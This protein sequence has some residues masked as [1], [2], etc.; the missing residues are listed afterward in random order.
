[1]VAGYAFKRDDA[2]LKKILELNTFIFTSKIFLAAMTAP[3]IRF[4]FPNLTGYNKRLD[5]LHAMQNQIRKEIQKH[6]VDLDEDN[7]RDF[8]DTYLIEMKNN[9]DPEF[10]KEQLVM[11]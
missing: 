2:E 5:A 8:I 6:E 1:M 4:I 9:D 3:W 7:P 10:C 11:I